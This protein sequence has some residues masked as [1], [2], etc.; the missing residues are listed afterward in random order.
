MVYFQREKYISTIGDILMKDYL[1]LMKA[2][3]NLP[4]NYLVHNMQ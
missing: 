2:L 1:M 3:Q 4:T